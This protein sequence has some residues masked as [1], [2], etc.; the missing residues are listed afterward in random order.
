ML[1]ITESAE[2]VTYLAE[3]KDGKKNYFVEGIFMQG[4]IKHRNGRLYPVSVLENEVNKYIKEKVDTKRAYGEL[5][6][7]QGPTINLPLASHVFT[8]IKKDGANFVGRAKI[9]DTNNGKVVKN[10]ID[11]GLSFG[12][13]SRGMGSLELK[14]GVNEVQSDFKLATAGDIVSDPSAPDAFVNGIMEGVEFWFNEENGLWERAAME[15]RQEVRSLKSGQIT[16][17]NLLNIFN[18]F[19]SKL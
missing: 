11:E 9:L 7:P 19:C 17:E 10:L 8:E 12:M 2:S 6:H 1:L 15:A 5:G 18:R 13:S 4:D 14:N 16:E 3:E